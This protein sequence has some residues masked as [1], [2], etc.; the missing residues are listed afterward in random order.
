MFN[1]LQPVGGV[2]RIVLNVSHP[3]YEYIRVIEEASPNDAIARQAAVGIILLLLSWGN[4][5][6]NI[7]SR[8]R[9]MVVQD[10]AHDWGRHVAE[11][12]RRLVEG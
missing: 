2:H 11:F 4:M 10:T 12:I 7:Y 5:E 6:H 8:E 3:I 1:V 9:L